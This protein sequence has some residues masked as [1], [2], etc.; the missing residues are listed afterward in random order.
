MVEQVEAERAKI[1]EG[2]DQ[3]PVLTLEEDGPHTVEQLVWRENMALHQHTGTQCSSHPPSGADGHLVE[4]LLQREAAH[5]A[6]P[7]GEH[8]RHGREAGCGQGGG[9]VGESEGSVGGGT[10]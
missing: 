7:A 2:R 9:C 8:I 10:L 4:P 6:V 3:P 1:E 5:H